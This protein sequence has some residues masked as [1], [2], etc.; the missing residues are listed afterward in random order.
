MN[1]RTIASMLAVSAAFAASAATLSADF[2][3]ETGPVNRALHSSGFAPRVTSQGATL[4][5]IKELNFDY[6]RTHDL[7]LISAGQ[8]IVDTQYIFPLMHLDPKDPRNY[9]FDATD[10]QLKLIRD[11]GNRIFYRLGASIEHSGPKVH[12]NT[13]IPDDFDKMAEVFAGTVRH[14]VNGWADG[15]KWDIKYW[16]IWNEPDGVNNMWCLPDGDGKVNT[17]DFARRDAKRR[18]LFCEFFVKCLKRLK[19]EFPE[20]KIG[21]P[22]FCTPKPRNEVWFKDLLAACK[23]AGV[24]PDFLSWHYYGYKPHEIMDHAE[25]MRKLCDSYGFKDCELI[26]NEWHYLGPYGWNGL[27]NNDP[28]T[29]ERVWSG[30]GSHNGID[31]SCFSLSVFAQLQTS[32]YDQA[33]FYGCRHTGAWG[34]MDAHKRKYKIWHALKLYGTI[35]KECDRLCASTREGTV[36]TLATKT[37]D[38]RQGWLLVADYNGKGDTIEVDVKGVKGVASATL[39][40]HKRNN[41]PVEVSFENGKLTLKKQLKGSAAFLVKFDL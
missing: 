17:K 20:L 4:K 16:G 30:P 13:L 1:I 34:Y 15:H 39:L 23:A 5:E 14:Y 12:F 24:A 21:G 6:T 27:R 7:A 3:K 2:S 33:Y 8:R 32:K 36:T 29:L 26:I 9:Y 41:A 31:S 38:G 40:D 18:K 10:Y 22:A 19:S 37:A 35:M 25:K 11:A 28:R